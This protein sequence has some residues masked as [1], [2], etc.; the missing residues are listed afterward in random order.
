MDRWA[1][2]TLLGDA[3]HPMYPV[4]SN[5]ASQAVLDAI[6][7]ADLLEDMAPPAALEAY[8]AARRPATT[9]IVLANRKGG[10][11]RVIDLIEQRA[12]E[13]FSD[14]HDVATPDELRSIVGDY[15]QMAGFA[16]EQVNR[17]D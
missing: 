11:E 3:A 1:R 15:S 13:G 5:G 14:L 4:G 7:L 12:P 17:A 16:Q 9:D 8:E 2:I 10:P 6:T